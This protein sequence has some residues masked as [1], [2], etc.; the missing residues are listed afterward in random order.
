MP[1][2]KQTIKTEIDALINN[3]KQLN[4]AE[5][6]EA[7]AEGLASIIENAL[8]SATVTVQVTTIGSATT[9][10]GTGTGSLS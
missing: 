5:S 9:Q 10:T 4:Q 2:V 8:K 1:I 6:Q 3:T 7:F